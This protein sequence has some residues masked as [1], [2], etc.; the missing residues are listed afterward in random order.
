MRFEPETFKFL[1]FAFYVCL[2]LQ[3]Y[4]VIKELYYGFFIL[5]CDFIGNFLCYYYIFIV[6]VEKEDRVNDQKEK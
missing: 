4:I 5:S 6:R 3:E 1:A 2:Q